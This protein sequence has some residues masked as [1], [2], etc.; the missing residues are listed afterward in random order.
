[1]KSIFFILFSA[2]AFFVHAQNPL[3]ITKNKLHL[4]TREEKD[5]FDHWLIDLRIQENLKLI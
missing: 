4:Y 1:M 3:S 5:Y 2:L